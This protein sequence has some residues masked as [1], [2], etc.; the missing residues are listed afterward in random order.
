MQAKAEAA[1]ERTQES[2]H[3]NRLAK[4]IDHKRAALEDWDDGL[5]RRLVPGR[6]LL[7]EFVGGLRTG[8]SY[9]QLRSLVLAEMKDDRELFPKE[10][11]EL[12]RAVLS[13]LD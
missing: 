9:E 13:G 4:L 5:W 7:R 8:L 11:G 12:A 3:P 2:L 6:R 1:S 10:F